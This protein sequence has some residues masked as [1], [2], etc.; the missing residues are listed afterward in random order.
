MKESM[1][2]SWWQ[3]RGWDYF[4]DIGE[5]KSE[6]MLFCLWFQSENLNKIWEKIYFIQM[7]KIH[8]K[9]T[10]DDKSIF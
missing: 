10:K 1:C 5:R 2:V 6:K 8:H 9:P 3:G 7:K 4:G